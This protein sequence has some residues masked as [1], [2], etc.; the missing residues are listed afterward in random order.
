MTTLQSFPTAC[1]ECRLTEGWPV[2]ATTMVQL[3][4]IRVDVRCRACGHQ[5]MEDLVQATSPDS[6][7]HAID[8]TLLLR[9]KPQ[10]RKGNDTTRV[11]P[12]QAAGPFRLLH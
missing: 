12:G 2:R 10:R 3:N 9:P 7:R 4:G 6:G 8:G 1:R 5:W 11:T